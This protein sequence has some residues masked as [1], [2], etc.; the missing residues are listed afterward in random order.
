MVPPRFRR[1]HPHHHA[2]LGGQRRLR[3]DATLAANI[4]GGIDPTT[5]PTLMSFPRVLGLSCFAFCWDYPCLL[6]YSYLWSHYVSL[7]FCYLRSLRVLS[8]VFIE[9]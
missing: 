2:W 8:Y 5:N 4:W 3:H 1:R 6:C 7:C 9:K